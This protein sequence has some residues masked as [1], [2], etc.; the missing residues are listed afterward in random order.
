MRD[1]ISDVVS[2]ARSY[3]DG[4]ANEIYKDIWGENIHM[5]LFESPDEDLPTA[6]ARTNEIMSRNVGL[7]PA[8]EVLDVGCGYGALARF[9]AEHY[10]CQ[11]LATN[12]SEKE[13]ERGRRLTSQAGMSHRVAFEWADF[14]ELPYRAN[15]FHVYW[16]QEAFLHAADKR[17][18]LEEAHRVLRP[19]GRLVFSELLVRGGT[20]EDIRARIYERVGAPEMWDDGDYLEALADLGFTIRSHQDWSENVALSYGWVREELE[21]RRAEFEDRVGREVVDATSDALRFWVDQ[22]RANRIGWVYYV[23]DK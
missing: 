2:E 23:A 10:G 7:T 15:R 1:A 3:Y 9:L 11:V 17:R 6:M 21:R 18:V 8:Q 16:S 22:A 5:G 20:P 12:I 13:L 4:A 14:H 19:G